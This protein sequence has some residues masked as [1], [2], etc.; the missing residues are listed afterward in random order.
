MNVHLHLKPFPVRVQT[1]EIKTWHM[2]NKIIDESVSVCTTK[3]HDERYTLTKY[4]FF[5]RRNVVER[6]GRLVVICGRLMWS[7]PRLQLQ[8]WVCECTVFGG[9]LDISLA[10]HFTCECG[11]LASRKANPGRV[12]RIRPEI[13]SLRNL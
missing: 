6:R 11:G 4:G 8:T 1:H 5:N 7:W 10:L 12:W 13:E 3:S 2:L 9:K